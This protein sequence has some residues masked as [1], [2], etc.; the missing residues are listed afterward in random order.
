MKP[1]VLLAAVTVLL[2]GCASVVEG[3]RQ[4]IAI[5]TGPPGANCGLT[6]EGFEIGRVNPTPG[7]AKIDKTK[8][9]ITVTCDKDGYQQAVIVN[10]SGTAAAAFANILLGIVSGGVAVAIDSAS[11]SDNKYDTPMT[12]KLVPVIA[13]APPS[14]QA[15][16]Q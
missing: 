3:S 15:N 14:P 8:H 6:R 11:G 10:K 2:G 12:V 9:D 7:V 1:F 16:S 13:A 5:A 4:E